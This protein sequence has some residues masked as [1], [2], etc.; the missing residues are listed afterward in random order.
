MLSVIMLSVI[1]LNVIILSVVMLS[2][3]MLNVVEPR[4]EPATRGNA[5]EQSVLKNVDNCWNIKNNF[6]LDTRD[7]IHNPSF[8]FSLSN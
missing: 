6:Y 7:L 3:V 4:T 2:A 1:M 8:S 5:M